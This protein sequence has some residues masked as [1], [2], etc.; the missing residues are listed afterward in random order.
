[1]FAFCE[2]L[3]SID[4]STFDTSSVTD[5]SRMFYACPNLKTI[6]VR[7]NW[8][9]GNDTKSTEMFKDSPKLVGGKGTLFNPKVTDASRAKIDGGKS[10]PG[11]FTA[12]K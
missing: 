8:N 2:R 11:Y 7:K 12:K 9:I 5:M 10:K 1:M 6:Y 4:V 3:T